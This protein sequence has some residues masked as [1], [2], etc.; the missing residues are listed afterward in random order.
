MSGKQTGFTLLEVMV[1]LAIVG[2]ALATASISISQMAGNASTLQERTYA[3]W[4]AQNKITELRLSG[5]IP[6]VKATSGELEFAN[7]TWGWRA[8]VSATDV[9]NL[10][11]VDVTISWPG[12][13]YGIY[14][15]SGFV[16]EP[17]APGLGSQAWTPKA[18]RSGV[19]Q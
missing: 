16:G 17:M 9:E 7:R 12:D 2:L 6:E 15:V 18:G 19:R 4:I 13:E 11:R 1:A 5:E 8:V 14:Q 10:R 3:S